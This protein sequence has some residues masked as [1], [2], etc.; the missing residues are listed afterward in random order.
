M[1]F[2]T[3]LQLQDLEIVDKK[4]ETIQTKQSERSDGP[5]PSVLTSDIGTPSAPDI[6]GTRESDHGASTSRKIPTVETKASEDSDISDQAL[7]STE[8]DEPLQGVTRT[9]NNLSLEERSIETPS[10]RCPSNRDSESGIELAEPTQAIPSGIESTT[11]LQ[12]SPPHSRNFYDDKWYLA[13][14][15]FNC[16]QALLLSGGILSGAYN[17]KGGFKGIYGSARDAGAMFLN[18]IEWVTFFAPVASFIFTFP[19]VGLKEIHFERPVCRHIFLLSRAKSILPYASAFAAASFSVFHSRP[20]VL[21]IS[22]L[23]FGDRIGFLWVYSSF[24][25]TYGIWYWIVTRKMK[26][27]GRSS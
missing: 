22:V 9:T 1:C 21:P 13:L 10:H 18:T 16:C 19:H 17:A 3:S 15:G 27:E 8:V 26:R 6:S 20:S 11:E 24:G 5:D 7:D 2:P 23:P 4:P 25:I 14:A 12:A